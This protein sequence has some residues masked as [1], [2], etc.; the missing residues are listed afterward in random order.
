MTMREASASVANVDHGARADRADSC[1]VQPTDGNPSECRFPR[2][3]QA[4]RSDAS[5]RAEAAY[6]DWSAAPPAERPLV[7]SRATTA[8][9]LYAVLKDHGVSRLRFADMLGIDEK[10]VRQWL[11]GSKPI[12]LSA[13]LAMPPDMG[14][15]LYERLLDARTGG[16]RSPKRAIA[17]L[18]EAVARVDVARASEGERRE[19]LKAA[20]EAQDRLSK[21][22]R[23]LAG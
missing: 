19:L 16:A 14:T 10:T 18:R 20:L 7:A 4:T 9:A 3:E 13:I 1:T 6:R 17:S 5:L 21:V 22:M 15:D 23:D 11:D 8:T 12:P 2:A